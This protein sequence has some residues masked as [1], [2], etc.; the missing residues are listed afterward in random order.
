MKEVDQPVNRFQ[1]DLEAPGWDDTKP[2][3]FLW[4]FFYVISIFIF[5][6][7]L[8]VNTIQKREKAKLISQAP[9]STSALKVVY[10][11]HH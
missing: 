7:I 2:S 10:R 5:F 6:V 9:S 8:V 4:V 1:Q 11:K 3:I